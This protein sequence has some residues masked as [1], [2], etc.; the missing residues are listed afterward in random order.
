MHRHTHLYSNT[1]THTLHGDYRDMVLFC[2]RFHQQDLIC[3]ALLYPKS[4]GNTSA[5]RWFLTAPQIRTNHHLTLPLV[6]DLIFPLTGVTTILVV[7]V[8]HWTSSDQLSAQSVLQGTDSGIGGLLYFHTC[9]NKEELCQYKS[10]E[11]TA[12][13]WIS[14]RVMIYHRNE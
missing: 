2:E 7:L 12:I 3:Q 10:A 4:V 14:E 6:L 1:H 8:F 11:E 9:I 13:K 5:F